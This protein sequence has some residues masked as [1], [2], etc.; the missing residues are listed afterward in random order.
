MQQNCCT[1]RDMQTLNTSRSDLHWF[2][3]AR[4][5]T[6]MASIVGI[7]RVVKLFFDWDWRGRVVRAVTENEYT[8]DRGIASETA[9]PY[10]ET[11]PE[12]SP[13]SLA[14]TA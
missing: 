3:W 2:L 10:R 14:G 9:I 6:S 13:R 7:T 12:R 4:F 8:C 11:R 1:S 5:N